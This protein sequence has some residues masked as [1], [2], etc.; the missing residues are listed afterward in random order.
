MNFEN[1][2]NEHGPERLGESGP[3]SQEQLPTIPISAFFSIELTGG[4]YRGYVD[5]RSTDLQFHDFVI[6]KR[7][8]WDARRRTTVVISAETSSLPPIRGQEKQRYKMTFSKSTVTGERL[9]D[10]TYLIRAVTSD[11]P[12]RVREEALRL[13][14]VLRQI[15]DDYQAG[16]DPEVI[17]HTLET[18]TSTVI[19]AVEWRNT[20]DGQPD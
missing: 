5:T 12:E 1:R 9:C 14:G 4:A 2:G 7:A 11:K 8:F 17:R 3:D 18:Q 16:V 6:D 13:H 10:V 15:I 20:T 19:E